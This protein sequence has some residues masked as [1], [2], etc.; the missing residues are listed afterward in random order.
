MGTIDAMK[1][2]LTE[3]ALDA[4]CEKFHI[5][6]NVHP[7]LPGHQSVTDSQLSIIAAAK[8]S[9]FEILCR[10]HGFVPTI[11]NFRRFYINSKNK[12]WMS[13]SKCS[14]T[15]PDPHPKPSEFH[16]DVCNYLAVNPAP[17][18]KLLKPFLCFVGI[19]RYYE[20][21]VNCYPTYLT[22]DDKEMDLF[23]FINHA[24][25]TKVRIWEREVREGEDVGH[26]VVNEEGAAD[27]QENLVDVGIIRIEDEVPA[28]V[29]EKAKGSRKRRKATGGASGSSLPPK[30]LSDDHGTSR[31]GASTGGKSVATLQSLLEGSTLPVEVGV[32]AATTVPFV[33]SSMTLTPEREGAVILSNAADAEV[34]SIVRSLVP[35]PPIMTTTVA[36]TV[37]AAASSVPVPRADDEPV[38][39]SIFADSTSADTVEPDIAGPS[40]PAGT[41]LS[42]DTFY[43]SQDM[44]SETLR[45]IYVPKW[46]VV[47]ESALDD[48]DVCRSLVDQLAPPVLFSQLRGMDYD[49]LFAE[50]NAG[51]HARHVLALRDAKIASLKARLSLKEAEAAEAIRLCGHVATV[52]A[53]KAARVSEMDGLRERNLALESEKNTLEGQVATLESAAGS[54]DTEL[55]SVNAQVAKLNDDLSSLQLSF[56]ELSAKAA[57]LDVTTMT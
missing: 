47:N 48:P 46:N 52:E 3:S 18:K 25:P 43:V 40:Q 49:Q 56:G 4:L 28:T 2:T 24:D 6:R 33:T 21:D 9:H 23:A 8:V 26:D 35:D 19:S 10:V 31:A 51:L 1:S 34:S 39:A 44:D 12:G 11:G 17:C 5:P 30:K 29:A 36:T 27:G 53:A 55:A 42:A 57:T 14:D 22:D 15:G 7:E 41:E 54:K 38:H 50:F 20:L 37:V 16:A 13:F 32:V 45:Q